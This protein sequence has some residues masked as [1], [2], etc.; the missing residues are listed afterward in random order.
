[1]RITGERESLEL[2]TEAGWSAYDIFLDTPMDRKAI[3]RLKELGT[4]TYLGML[5][6]PFYR[7]EK[8][9]YLIKGLE[10]SCMLRVSMLQ[11][12]EIILK[13]VKEQLESEE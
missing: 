5:K 10:G 2:C 12:E 4:M 9:H 1:M 7:I 8:E 6:H 3:Q 11:G 13:R